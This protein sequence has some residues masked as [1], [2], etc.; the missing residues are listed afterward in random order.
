MTIQESPNL[1]NSMNFA[2]QSYVSPS[3][4]LSPSSPFATD[5]S[6]AFNPISLAVTQRKDTEPNAAHALNAYDC[7]F[8]IVD[9]AKFFNSESLVQQDIVVWL[10]LG[11]HVSL[12]ASLSARSLRP[13]DTQLPSR[14]STPLTRVISPTP[15]SRPLKPDS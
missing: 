8:P 13:A 11:M 2:K 9:F 14:S 10:N 5:P 4:P 15:S 3:L 1:I 7:E 6:F 12:Y